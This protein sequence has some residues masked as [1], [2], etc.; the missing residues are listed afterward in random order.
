MS[1]RIKTCD[2]CGGTGYVPGEHE[3]ERTEVCPD[4][5]GTGVSDDS[6]DD[7][8]EVRDRRVNRYDD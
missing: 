1:R 2:Y 3:Y 4:C 5:G 7:A 8:D 6:D